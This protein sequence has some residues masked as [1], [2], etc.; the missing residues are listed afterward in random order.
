MLTF[1]PDPADLRW[2]VRSLDLGSFSAAAR[3]QNVAV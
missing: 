1:L 2:L 3:E